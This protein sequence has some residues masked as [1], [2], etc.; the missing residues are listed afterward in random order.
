MVICSKLENKKDFTLNRV[1]KISCKEV[2]CL[3]PCKEASCQLPWESGRTATV[4]SQNPCLTWPAPGPLGLP[5][6]VCSRQPELPQQLGQVPISAP[7]PT[8][9][10]NLLLSSH[11]LWCPSLICILPLYILR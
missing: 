11:P 3:L 7:S 10:R 2:H 1:F 5:A 4:G 6:C 9:A 8:F